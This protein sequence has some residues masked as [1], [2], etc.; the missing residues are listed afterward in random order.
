MVFSI[1]TMDR[2]LYIALLI[3]A[4]IR[5]DLF[6]QSNFELPKVIRPSPEAAAFLRYGEIPVDNSS[7]VPKIDIPFYTIKSRQLQ[8]PVSIS[9]HA[10]GIKV[11]DL[12]TPVGLGWVLN[13]GGIIARTT[14]GL[15]DEDRVKAHFK[16]AAEKD[17]AI[18]ANPYDFTGIGF[19]LENDDQLD[20]QSDRFYYQLPSG[21]SGVFRYNFSNDQ[22]IKIPYSPIRITKNQNESY[23]HEIKGFEIVDD[24]G[25]IY[26]FSVREYCDEVYVEFPD[27]WLLST[28]ITA[29]KT[30][31][32][33]FTY[34]NFRN[35]YNHPSYSQ[36]LSW[37]PSGA[38]SLCGGTENYPQFLLDHTATLLTDGAIYDRQGCVPLLDSIIW[39]NGIMTFDYSSDRQDGPPYRLSRAKIF[40]RISG[41][42]K[43]RIDL[44]HTYFGT[45]A[46]NNLRLRL[47]QVV[48]SP[49][50]QEKQPYTFVY[51]PNALPAYYYKAG[52]KF[53]EDYWGY[54]NGANSTSNISRRFL[55]QDEQ[56][57]YI[58]YRDP[59]SDGY[60]KAC[61]LEE[62]HFPTGGKTVFEFGRH[63]AANVYEYDPS[64]LPYGSFRV[65][66]IKS[67]A[68]DQHL[69]FQ[70]TYVY[71]N[72][73]LDRVDSYHYT[74]AKNFVAWG[75]V[76]DAGL[77]VYSRMNVFSSRILPFKPTL[78]RTVIEYDGTED[79]NVGKTEYNYTIMDYGYSLGGRGEVPDGHSSEYSHPMYIHPYERDRGD[80]VPYLTEKNYY[81]KNNT[82]TGYTMIRQELKDYNYFRSANMFPTGVHVVR[83]LNYLNSG[84]GPIY[85]YYV[86][87]INPACGAAYPTF[88]QDYFNTFLYFDTYAYEEAFLQVQE[89]VQEYDM[90]GNVTL[91]SRTNYTLDP[92]Y[93]KVRERTMTN[94]KGDVFKTTFQYPF[95]LSPQEPYQ[96]MVTRNMVSSVVEQKQYKNETEFLQSVKTNFNS[97]PGSQVIK[98]ASVESKRATS[99]YEPR[100]QYQG[101][102]VYGNVSS[103]SKAKDGV[104]CYFYDY[105]QNLPVAE[106]KNGVVGHMAYTSFEAEGKGNWSFQGR[107]VA[108]SLAPTGEKSYALGTLQATGLSTSKTYILSY[109]YNAGASVTVG[110]GTSSALTTVPGRNGWTWVKR[111][112]TNASSVTLSGSGRIDEVRLYPEGAEMTTYTYDPL[113][114]VKSSTD[115]NN[116]TLYYTYD[117]D[118]RLR[119]V[120]DE[121]GNIVKTYAYHFKK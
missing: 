110:G 41:A 54:N 3:L 11:N 25:D 1:V 94:S 16:N 112:I 107:G 59:W 98:P 44:V 76:G 103:V 111:R 61:M 120:S 89:G 26:A 96:T 14:L 83:L 10:S 34:K 13:A 45:P 105:V 37:L 58:G 46:D 116:K 62:I 104:V 47:D 51:N 87:S 86:N 8:L 91:S 20:R 69:A 33:R 81:R 55:R 60:G 119:S 97:W 28:M 118:G 12:A 114:G 71:Q 117:P 92:D 53:N 27:T 35:E 82:G 121:K 100:L 52:N 72:P 36:I 109:A 95:D 67:Y 90:N 9:Y 42:E 48:M 32:I 66:S 19:H 29:D 80:P 74:V 115:T 63:V 68:D 102:D 57:V 84:Y 108:E 31:T 7:G 43:K 65:N 101:Y 78:Y 49:A 75:A 50:Q 30:D 15:R 22:L 64:E 39:A 99:D 2:A 4:L 73:V 38:V 79:V 85:G 21:K 88:F 56:S 113:V 77:A 93:F 24:N 106:V 70:K 6:A 23:P 5:Q 18:A 17:A 40:D